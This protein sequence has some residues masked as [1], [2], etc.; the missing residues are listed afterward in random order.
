MRIFAILFVLNTVWAKTV[1][2][3]VDRNRLDEGELVTLSVEVSGSEN[4]AKIN[5]NPIKKDFEI[6]SGPSQQTNIQ[7]INGSMTSTKTLSWSLSPIRGGSLTIPSLSGTVDG[8]SFRGKPIKIQVKKAS[9]SDDNSVFI[10]GEIDKSKAYLG[11]QITLT[12]KLF[13]NK[14]ISIEPFQMPEFPGFWVEDIYTPQRVQYRNVTIKG[15]KYQVA[16][17]GQKALFPLPSEKHSI[18]SITV[19]VQVE[20]KRKKRRRDPFFDP[21]FD[22]FF[23]E[24]KTKIIRSKEQKVEILPYPEPK[25]FD[26][27]GAV[28][29]FAIIAKTDRDT[30]KVNEG[31]TFTISLR[32]TGNLGLF[33]LPEIIFPDE[34]EAFPPT[35]KYEKDSFR[36]DITGSHI[37][38]YILMPR[39]I[40]N[41]TLPR[42]QMSY[43]NPKTG[44]WERTKTDPIIIPI[45][46]GETGISQGSG[47]TKRE[48]ELIGED[49][50]FIHTGPIHLSTSGAHK[51]NTVF[52]IYLCS[53]LVFASPTFISKFTGYRLSTAEGRQIRGAL[54]TGL[55]ELKKQTDKPFEKA[56]KAFYIY[57][58]NKLILSS[59]NL[60]S[61][62]VHTYLKEKIPS[63]LMDKTISLLKICDAGKYAPGGIDR[64][65]TIL[66]DMA[67]LMKQIEKEMI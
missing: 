62:S 19:K 3:S 53:I 40:G 60:D 61:G 46:P 47:L 6:V 52:L 10:I 17:L 37:W 14:N 39:T 22:S 8:K 35:D 42:I 67:E 11:E 23:T 33:S 50:R 59:H 25:P 29:S 65:A 41:I 54:R 56:S 44:N 45:L 4:F 9:D 32:G 5:I 18:P 49:I 13:K 43:F 26:F 15:V 38:E 66:A 48:V 58:K 36:D 64:E 31:F 30:S 16:T 55:Q 1:Q 63:E 57:L 51:R 2:I 21:F 24:T 7:W 28:G 27:S 12:Y 20:S 34:I